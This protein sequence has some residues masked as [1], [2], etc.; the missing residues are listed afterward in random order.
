MSALGERLRAFSIQEQILV[1]E[2]NILKYFPFLS[3]G[4]ISH[5]IELGITHTIDFILN[6]FAGILT[7]LFSIIAIMVIL[8]F[9][10]FFIVKDRQRI[11]KGLLN[12]LPNRYFEMSYWIMKKVSYQL[13]RYVRGWI[14]DAIFVGAACGI[15][16]WLLGI[17]NSFALGVIA[18]VGHLVPY[19]G[20]IIGGIPAIFISLL[21]FGNLS[22]LPLILLLM[23]CI[24]AFDNGVLQP[25]VFSKSVGMHPLVIIL[26]IIAGSQAAGLP[27]MLFAVP[28]ATVIKTASSEIYFALKN[29]K[30]ARL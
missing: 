20:P 24:Y 7:N 19:F 15:G 23:G 27:G 2:T 5:R 11:L 6:E 9:T 12:I 10:T 14:I 29:Y 17:E 26:L 18:G 30:I 16:F 8:P 1:A 21:Q 13:G 3:K 28:F 25:Y 4:V 22:A